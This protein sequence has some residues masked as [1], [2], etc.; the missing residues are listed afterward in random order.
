MNSIRIDLGHV[1]RDLNLPAPSVE[2][3]VALLDEG[4]TVPF[5]TR[6][7]KDQT[8]GL[9]EEQIR[10]IQ[11][12]VTKLRQLADR[13]Q[14]ILK[15]IESQGKL[16]P[17]LANQI[18]N[19]TTPKRLEDLYLP[20]K[21]KKQTLAT[22]AREQGLEPLA[23]EIL[24]ANPAA[25]DLEARLTGLV[26]PEKELS[27]ST[28]V[29][30][31]VGYLIAERFGENAE[32]RGR[33]R[34]IF[35]RTGKLICSKVEAPLASQ[36]TG[37]RGQETAVRSQE[38]G[39]SV[40]EAAIA[41]VPEAVPSDASTA[42]QS[43]PVEP[44]N[45]APVAES[46]APPAQEMVSH[47]I[48]EQEH[49]VAEQEAAAAES[50]DS[51]QSQISD[52]KSEIPAGSEDLSSPSSQPPTPSPESA[53]A[54]SPVPAGR[55]FE[56]PQ[57]GAKSADVQ[58]ALKKAK[59]KKKKKIIGEHAFKDYYEF[60]EPLHKVPPHRVLAINRGERARAIRVK[61]EADFDA[62]QREAEQLLI[63]EGH[64]HAE[65]LRQCV[66]DAL[67]RLLIPSLER[68]IRREQTDKAEEHAVEVF[69][70]NLRKLLLQQP[71][72]GKRVLAIDPGFKSGCKMVALDE[73]GNV[74][75]HSVV[76][77]IGKEDRRAK[78][79]E[80]LANFARQNKA[81]VVAIGNG[82]GCRET[83]QLVADV[84]SEELKERDMAYAVVNEAGASIYSTSPLGREELPQF[85]AL[86][87][88][89]ISIGRRLLD[90][91][92]EMVKIN[93]ANLG[94]G[95]YQHDV[96]AKH[97]QE[98]LDSVVESCVNFVGVD[99]NSA[100]P[101]LLRYVSGMNALTARRVYEYRREHGPFKNRDELK[102]VTG[103]GDQTFVQS[104]GFLKI[105]GGEN[106][107]DATWIHPESYEIAQRVLGKLG[108][109]LDELAKHVPAPPKPAEKPV[110]AAELVVSQE[111][112]VSGQ[113]SEAATRGVSEAAET[114]TRSVSEGVQEV[115]G[116]TS[117]VQSSEAPA[118]EPA[119]ENVASAA[120]DAPVAEAPVAESPAPDSPSAVA[121]S[122][123]SQILDL[124]SEIPPPQ[125]PAAVE[126][127]APV[128]P[129]RP[130]PIAERASTVDIAKL[131]EELAVGTHLLQDILSSLT[132]P[133]LD[134]RDNVPAPVFRRGI[135]KL[136]DLQAGM[137]L[138]GTVLNVVDFGVFVD[139]GLSDSGLVHI[140]RLADR[141]IKDP[142]EVVGVGDIL[143]VW[144]VEV[145]KTRRR[146]S[147]T[148]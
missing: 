115:P 74:L 60:Q 84:L 94:V 81:Q 134:P 67:T 109:E 142:H 53:P 111:S 148:A 44:E 129:P 42:T 70:R 118:T 103:F 88:G 144:V 69:I 39:V 43:A 114:L 5:I 133:G 125:P 127:P 112:G 17:E 20:F 63:P 132:R 101:A 104:A 89:A 136:E 128:E 15:S 11:W 26:D 141:F 73:F 45:S 40:Q 10:S 78:A 122:S 22:K 9:D 62:M 27:N 58:Q 55:L 135:M 71:T 86:Q 54:D 61:I 35:H 4:N 1:A 92:S 36:E 46:T 120:A 126:P 99:V 28:D 145:D 16:T 14:T 117:E 21:P 100:S 123:E 107:L 108:V 119:V 30:Q 130:N 131:A 87:R 29:L 85:D 33:L 47:V 147:L 91:L 64:P 34:R 76:Y 2:R 57:E 96:K 41:P 8:G 105:I 66:R 48:V 143:K 3:T 51:S 68:E 79:R 52:L 98:S 50:A 121:G 23:I 18:Q 116:S 75:A 6:Y 137:E 106:P 25:A 32:L 82:T 19:A 113:E 80:R 12:V 7:R 102:K 49:K 37:E 13:K 110:F 146:V 97:L 83:E 65:F 31:G 139:I 59:K 77:V 24:E 138:Q 56:K 93:P 95:L 124:K 140:S 38:S 90:P 72:R